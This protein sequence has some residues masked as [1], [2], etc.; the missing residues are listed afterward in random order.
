MLYYWVYMEFNPLNLL[1]ILFF[2][3]KVGFLKT[4]IE[5]TIFLCQV[6]IRF[7]HQLLQ[8]ATNLS[9]GQKQRLSMARAFIR[10]PKFLILD[11]STSAI[12]ALS[13]AAV[14]QALREA[15]PDSTVFFISS[16]ISSIMD[17]DQ[18]LVMEDGRLEAI[19]THD[20][21]LATSKVYRA[22]YKSQSGK[23]VTYA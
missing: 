14:Q 7:G 6:I 16:K 15:Y 5:N 10:E 11:D 20:T 1:S 17:A 13:E 12:D 23:E 4:I 19:G 22:I 2:F 18:I 21:L 9:G 8:D 3:C